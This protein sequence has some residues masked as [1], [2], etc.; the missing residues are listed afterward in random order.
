MLYILNLHSD[1]HQLFLN[2]NEKQSK[3]NRDPGKFLSDT[4]GKVAKN[5]TKHILAIKCEIIGKFGLWQ[6]CYFAQK[7]TFIQVF[8]ASS[9]VFNSKGRKSPLR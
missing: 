4:W 2:K 8:P 5:L 7:E 6:S 9:K 1:V 3:Q